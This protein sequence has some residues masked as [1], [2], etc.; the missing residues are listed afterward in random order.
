MQASFG[1]KATTIHRQASDVRFTHGG[2][3][4][5]NILMRDGQLVAIIDWQYAGW[6]SE[7]WEYTKAHHN[8]VYR[9]KFYATLR[10]R[11]PRCD[12]ELAAERDS[13][14][15]YDQPLGIKVN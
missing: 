10:E 11:I 3:A 4:V 12:D 8:M 7:Y 5:G 2:L 6:Y 1:E 9:P 15:C 14:R 13:W